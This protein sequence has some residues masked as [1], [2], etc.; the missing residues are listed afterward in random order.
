M[1]SDTYDVLFCMLFPHKCYRMHAE[2]HQA[3]YFIMHFKFFI[4]YIKCM[5][6]LQDIGGDLHDSSLQV[7]IASKANSS[8]MHIF[9][10][11]SSIS[12]NQI[13]QFWVLHFIYLFP[14]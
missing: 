4:S 3:P 12:C 10:G 14:L 11:S 7:C 9:R 2:L 1:S 8:L 6:E 5:Y 13:P